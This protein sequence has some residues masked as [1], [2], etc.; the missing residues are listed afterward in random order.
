VASQLLLCQ[1]CFDSAALEQ[2][3]QAHLIWTVYSFLHAQ[4]LCEHPE[5]PKMGY[6]SCNRCR[7]GII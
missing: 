1:A 4:M 3:P 5:Y 6:F 7:C 2:I